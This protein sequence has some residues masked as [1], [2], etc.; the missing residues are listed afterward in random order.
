MLV[1]VNCMSLVWDITGLLYFLCFTFPENFW[2]CVLLCILHYFSLC[3]LS[4]NRFMFIGLCHF[5][6]YLV[7]IYFLIK[8]NIAGIVSHDPSHG[9][10][11]NSPLFP[12]SVDRC[13][14]PNQA[15]ILGDWFIMAKVATDD[16]ADQNQPSSGLCKGHPVVIVIKG[17]QYIH[18]LN[19]QDI[20]I[21]WQSTIHRYCNLTNSMI[22]KMSFA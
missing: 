5:A 15:F 21:Q 13:N 19:N 2:L 3:L 14:R 4:I 6:S 18:Q 11:E 12:P 8:Y 1:F 16:R 20:I 9:L 10:Q 22:L 7:S 17:M